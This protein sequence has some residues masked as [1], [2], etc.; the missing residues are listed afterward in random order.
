[1][2]AKEG[3]YFSVCL[4][5]IKVPC[6]FKHGSTKPVN[7]TA[8]NIRIIQ[9]GYFNTYSKNFFNLA[10]R[11]IQN[12]TRVVFVEEYNKSILPV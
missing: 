6:I 3:I 4:A 2:N 10:F 1:M 7:L 5:N 9:F 8:G 12:W 11:T